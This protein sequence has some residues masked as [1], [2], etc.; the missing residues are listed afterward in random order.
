MTIFL[1]ALLSATAPSMGIGR[2]AWAFSTVG[3]SEWCPAGNVM[4]DLRTGHYELTPRAPRSVCNKPALQRPIR[5]GTLSA[6]QLAPLR[7]AYL[8][9]LREGLEKPVCQGGGLPEST[10]VII[11]NG[12]LRVLVVTDGSRS[13]SAPD[14]LG[15]WT[16]AAMDLK[17]LLD[18]VFS[19]SDYTQER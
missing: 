6:R 4:L 3:Q 12:G 1:A 14:A 19:P 5:R 11:D 2:T 18:R 7:A 16:H 9:A 8:R 17:D 13:I 10:E 15:C